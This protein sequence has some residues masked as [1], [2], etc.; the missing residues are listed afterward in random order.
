MVAT[1]F[2]FL[3]MC[4]IG[5]PLHEMWP[6]CV[7]LTRNVIVRVVKQCLKH[8]ETGLAVAGRA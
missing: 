7:G 2:S 4:E 5:R 1:I 3:A 6:E 8:A